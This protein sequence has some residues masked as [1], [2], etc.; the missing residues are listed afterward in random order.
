MTIVVPIGGWIADFL[1]THNMMSTTNV[2]KLMNCG[3]FG[4]EALFLLIL[5]FSRGYTA[6]VIFLIF[7]VGFSG[8]AISGFNVNH[9]DIAPK[10]ASV[11]M[12]LSNGAG[13]F[14][15][16]I[17]PLLV[18]YLTR[19]KKVSDWKQVFIIAACIHIFGVIFYAIFASGERQRWA[20]PTSEQLHILNNEHYD[21]IVLLSLVT[22]IDAMFVAVGAIT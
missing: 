1:R 14:S 15:G 18:S 20:D 16:M 8:F 19:D 10:Y 3:G 2:R 12:G 5:A 9:L 17:C 11:L 22:F 13:T 4:M 7:A 21:V 6:A